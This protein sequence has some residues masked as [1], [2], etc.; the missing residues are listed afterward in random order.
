[1]KKFLGGTASGICAGLAVL[2]GCAVYLASG[3]KYV[4]AALFSVALLSICLLGFSLYT[5]K[6][7]FI[8]E[9]HDKEAFR[10]LL[11]GLLGNAIGAIGGGY[12]L[13]Y[14]IPALKT[15]AQELCSGK[16]AN[17]S[18][19]QTLVRGIFCGILMYLAVRIFRDNKNI[20]GI[21]FCI[22]VFILS[23]FE[24]SIADIGY[25]AIDGRVSTEAL[26]FVWT[27]ILGNSLGSMLFPAL[28]LPFRLREN[29]GNSGK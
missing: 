7:G 12:A 3:N 13:G 9:K 5:G 10:V 21:L 20:A 11:S 19:A 22:P 14:A 27:V 15:A 6:I 25:F 8:P 28:T 16:L 2:I 26:G 23:G 1:M 4:G 18:F 17:Q 29:P 24:H